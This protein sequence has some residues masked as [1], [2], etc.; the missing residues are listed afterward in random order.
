[1]CADV[2]GSYMLVVVS[3]DYKIL[4]LDD[5]VKICNA[6]LS[7]R[8]LIIRSAEYIE[9]KV[10]FNFFSSWLCCYMAQMNPLIGPRLHQNTVLIMAREWGNPLPDA[11][12]WQPAKH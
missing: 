4:F 7:K 3:R 9:L 1:M 8:L 12:T 6:Q 10:N 11:D 2:N 5:L